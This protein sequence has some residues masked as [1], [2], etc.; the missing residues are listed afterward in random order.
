MAFGLYLQI[1]P[2]SAAF[3]FAFITLGS[4]RTHPRPS[5][6]FALEQLLRRSAH[7]CALKTQA[8][9]AWPSMKSRSTD[10]L[11]VE[12]LIVQGE[13]P[14]VGLA[15][16]A[17]A[18][19]SH[20]WWALPARRLAAVRAAALIIGLALAL[21]ANSARA[22]VQPLDYSDTANWV[23]LPGGCQDNL[24]A[25]VVEASGAPGLE[26][27]APASAQPIDCLYLY[28][29]VSE[30]GTLSA[31]A[32]VTEAERR[33]V[34][35]QAARFASVCRL[36]VPF[37]RQIT[38]SAMLGGAK[39]SS[40]EEFRTAD[41]RAKAD[42]LAAWDRYLAEENQGRGFVLIGHSQ[43]AAMVTAIL[44]QRIEGRPVQ[45]QLLSAIMPGWFV[46]APPGEE[47]GGTFKSIPP[48][49][50]EAQTGCVIVFNAVRADRPI[51][52]EKVIRVEGEEA[53]CTN[54]AALAGGRGVLRPY[55]STDGETIIPA[56]SAPQPPWTKTPV[57][58][59]APFVSLPG[60]YWAECR[61][62]DHG[63]Y[64]AVGTSD[65]SG[66]QRTGEMTGDWMIGGSPEPTMGLHLIDMNLTMG[67]L[68]DVVARQ[69]AA[70]RSRD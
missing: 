30:S 17:A 48:C 60:L 37:Y 4:R 40:P 55:L 34:R 6:P 53:I 63:V 28:P 43:G 35:Q 23:C 65:A 47:I 31:Q 56:L 57:E 11:G 50:R 20:C 2:P 39:P 26:P 66:D 41:A 51:P 67:N 44:Q 7:D 38:T 27:F 42:V 22:E 3:W 14:Y 13:M 64:L 32:G 36:Y 46:L 12:H 21:G 62:D 29:T 54:P 16:M 52:A 49:Q 70:Y 59:A 18:A 8:R 15:E 61:S 25:A 33:A 24:T 5:L 68:L 58:I 69:S 10:L 9:R 19:V 1:E 45:D